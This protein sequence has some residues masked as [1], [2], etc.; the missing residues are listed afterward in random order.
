MLRPLAVLLFAIMCAGCAGV[1]APAC[2]LGQAMVETQ[3][4][5]GMSKPSGA[6]VSEREWQAFVA[7]EIAP[8]FPEG[9]SVLDGAGFWRD[10]KTQK[11]ISEK[12]KVVVRMHDDNADAAIGEIVAA[13][14]TQFQQDAVMRVDRPV[15]AQF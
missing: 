14:K 4:Y 11:T 10:A 7:A 15:C 5:F 1:A 12:S 3:L 8:K 6:L 2:G 13:Y 9:F